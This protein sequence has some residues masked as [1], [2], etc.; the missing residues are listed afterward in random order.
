MDHETR[1]KCDTVRKDASLKLIAQT[2]QAVTSKI[3]SSLGMNSNINNTHTEELER[4]L[5]Q[6]KERKLQKARVLNFNVHNKDNSLDDFYVTKVKADGNCFYRCIALDIYGSQEKHKHIRDKI[7]EHMNNNI[8]QYSVHID[9]NTS[10]H[11]TNQLYIDGR[12]SSWATEAEIYAVATLYSAIAQIYSVEH[13]A[14]TKLTFEPTTKKSKIKHK[15]FLRLEN[16]HYDFLNVKNKSHTSNITVSRTESA[17]FDWYNMEPIPNELETSK[18]NSETV[19]SHITSSI[20]CSSEKADEHTHLERRFRN[21]EVNSVHTD[22]SS[23][24][25]NLSSRF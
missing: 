4:V 3:I 9:G 16:Q 18:S 14:A 11:M 20:E 10:V 12:V 24:V 23:T 19:E 15:I 22:L 5:H 21:K 2:E 6:K 7:V 1:E 8:D 17:K 13:N 25:V